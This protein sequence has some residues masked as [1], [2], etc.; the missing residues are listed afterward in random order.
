MRATGKTFRLILSALKMASEGKYVIFQCQTHKMA[1][2]SFER[3]V[4]MTS[5]YMMPV[6]PDRMTLEIGEGSIEFEGWLRTGTITNYG[7]CFDKKPS[8]W[9]RIFGA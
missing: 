3:A 4:R 6:I 9:Q 5:E 8:L 1:R 7:D 2:W